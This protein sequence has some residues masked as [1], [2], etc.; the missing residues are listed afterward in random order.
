M[1]LVGGQRGVGTKGDEWGERR[2][3]GTM[4]TRGGQDLGA[5]RGATVGKRARGILAVSLP[6]RRVAKSHD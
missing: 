6:P 1:A 3:S 2:D 4:G 5:V